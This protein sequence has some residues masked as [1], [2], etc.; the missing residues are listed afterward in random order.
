MKISH[1]NILFLLTCTVFI[2]CGFSDKHDENNLTYWSSN[3]MDEIRFAKASTENWNNNNEHF[4][5]SFQP[6]PEGQSSEEII[7]AAVVGKTTPD[8]YS[9]M[10][11]G[12]V[13][14]YAEA[15]VLIPLDTLDGFMQ[16]IY[17]RCDS[18]VVEEI[19]AL[20]GHIYQIPWKIN[21]IMLIYNENIINGLTLGSPPKTYSEFLSSSKEFQNDEDGD[22]YVDRWFGYSEVQVTWW[23]R[24]FDFYP[25]YL[26]ASGGAPLIK[27]RKA[28]FNNKYSVEVFKFLRTLYSKNYF[29]IEKLSS[30][31]DVFLSSVI[32]TRFTGPWEI[33]HADKFAPKG[34]KYSFT[35]MPIPDDHTGPVYTYGD[36]KNIVIFNT[37]KYPERAWQYLKTMID[38]EGDLQLLKITNQL[39]RRKDLLTNT[40]FEDYFNNNHKMKI[41]ARQAKYVRGTDASPV[42]KEIFDLISQQYEAC[43]VYGTKSPEQ[44]VKDAADAVNL[45]F[46]E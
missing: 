36:P 31:Q 41:I 24:F 17:K 20:D 40:L 2:S 34:F 42:L 12:D 6:V 29:S 39:P 7:L 13:E 10:W 27:D 1:I 35:E 37:C 26:A 25:L 3:N 14:A 46:L 44:A 23:Q 4:K 16:F 21:P 33:S 9:N 15:G 45:L 11:Q 30:R 32:A 22:G 8:I 5:V 43:V 28:V 18:T 19:R 38:D